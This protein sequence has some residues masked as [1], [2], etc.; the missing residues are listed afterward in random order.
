MARST[1]GADYQDVPRPVA[2]LADEYPPNSYDPPHSHKRGQLAYAISGVLV[3]STPDATYVVPP[4]RAVWVPS[5][6]V[7]EA[8]T[9][10]LVSLRTLY[11]DDSV[12]RELPR[13]CMTIE[14]SSLLRELI[15]EA[16]R[17][18]IE[19]EYD[20]RDGRVMSLI[21]DEILH[22]NAAPLQVPMPRHPQLLKVC[23]AILRDPAQSDVLDHW[24]DSAG[25]CRRTFTRL[26]RR[27]TGVTFATWRQN[28]RLMEAMSR[29]ANGQSITAV[30]CDVGYSSPSAFT[31][32]FRRAFGVPPTQYCAESSHH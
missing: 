19:Y 29:L 11:L 18:P 5:G 3:L 13:S 17:I 4:Q 14:V 28:V 7:H 20:S 6:V 16:T 1:R 22:A 21:V 15:V 25:M 31:A 10:G 24:A 2:A 30:A 9:R 23:Q 8:R 12:C 32:M 27:E 26:F